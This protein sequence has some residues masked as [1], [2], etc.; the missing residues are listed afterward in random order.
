MLAAQSEQTLHLN[1]V[2][3]NL[4]AAIVHQCSQGGKT[5]ALPQSAFR[6]EFLCNRFFFLG[7]KI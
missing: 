4:L 5:K 6:S 2:K 7:I 1:E 3:V